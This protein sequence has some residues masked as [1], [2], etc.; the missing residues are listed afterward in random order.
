MMKQIIAAIC[1]F[2]A[3]Y[4]VCYFT[5]ESVVANKIV[6][7]S[8]QAEVKRVD[9][10]LKKNQHA[11]DSFE[12]AR[13]NLDSAFD[14]LEKEAA[15]DAPNSIDDCEL[16]ADRLQRWR[17]ANAGTVEGV[18]AVESDAGARTVAAAGERQDADA[19]SRSQDGRKDVPQAGDADVRATSQLG[20]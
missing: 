15:H 20:N 18:A 5:G 1:L 19:G 14:Q 17:A 12:K 11:G 8:S 7:K 13:R 10:N 6:A 9:K 3:G 2:C 4:A 16:P